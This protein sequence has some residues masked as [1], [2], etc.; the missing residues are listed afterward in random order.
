MSEKRMRPGSNPG[1]SMP[2]GGMAPVEKSRDLKQAYANLLH[3]IGKYRGMILTAAV[4]SLAGAVLNL[5]GPGQLSKITNL[6]TDGLSSHINIAAIVHIAAL[7]AVLYLLG[8]IFNYAQGWLMATVSQRVTQNMRRDIARKID[9]LPLQY[10]DTH[11]TGDVLSRVTNDVDT[12]SQ[13]MNQ[14][15]STLVS[16]ICLLLGSVIMMFATNWIMAVTGILAALLGFAFMMMIIQKSQG[17]FARQQTEL[18][19]IDGHVEEIYGGHNVVKAY[20]GETAARKEFHTMNNTLYTCAWKSQF[21]SGLMQPLMIF[22]GNLAYVVVCITGAV[23]AVQGKISFGT[24]VAFMLYIRLF[25]QPLQNISQAATSVQSM[26]AACE[27]VFDFLDETEMK[28][29]TEKKEN[30]Q[31][32]HGDVAFDHVSFGYTPEKEIIHDFS[33]ASHAGQKIAIVGPTGAGK[34]TLVNL[35]MRF[36]E[37]NSGSISIDGTSIQA[38]T[39]ANVHEQFGMVLQDTWLFEGTIR[40]NLVYNQKNVT[41]EQLDKVCRA[42]G[43]SDLI[44][45]LPS[46]YDTVLNDN[47]SLSAGQRQ[48]LTIA[49][50]MVKDAPLL[51]LDEATSSV[52]T[53]TELQV[54]RA[55]DNLMRGRTSFVIAHR[56]STIKNADLILVLKDGDILESGT[57]A[58]LLAKGGFYAELYNSQFDKAS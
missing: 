45:Q 8:F 6:I 58:A 50:A 38:V 14:S 27:R 49:R 35:L 10:F 40:E 47:A 39:R 55:M 17:Y 1:N 26:A 13:S 56:L 20:N 22:I 37:V 11:T 48:L 2:G 12:V 16:S 36:Y 34:T 52:D 57:H 15:F 19:R 54:Q 31:A 18:G 41:D 25:T 51:I 53:R 43:L 46:G 44:Q 32:V 33:A 21:L 3:Y 9:R 23:L 28:P 7:L 42:V 24:I 4:L 29:E 5:I 30:L